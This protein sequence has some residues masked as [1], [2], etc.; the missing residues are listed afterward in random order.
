[1]VENDRSFEAVPTRGGCARGPRWGRWLLR[2]AAAW[3]VVFL[4]AWVAAA[5]VWSHR[6]RLVN[7]W[8][9]G[10]SLPVRA[11]VEGLDWRRGRIVLHQLT[12]RDPAGRVVGTVRTVTAVV[13]AGSLQRRTLEEV[14]IEGV[15]FSAT[16]ESWAAL[17]SASSGPGSTRAGSPSPAAAGSR[18]AGPA[19]KVAKLTV[20][21]A[22]ADLAPRPGARLQAS[23]DWI[24]GGIVSDAAGGVSFAPQHLVVHALEAAAPDGGRISAPGA[25]VTWSWQPEAGPR[26]PGELN[27]AE[28]H[29]PRGALTLTPGLLGL[30]GSGPA[31][32]GPD[33]PAGPVPS[34]A[35]RPRVRVGSLT[36]G[37]MPVAWQFPGQTTVA[38]EL[39]LTAAGLEW[40]PDWALAHFSARLREAAARASGPGETSTAAAASVDLRGHRAAGGPVV[41]EAVTLLQPVVRLNGERWGPQRPAGA[42]A[43]VASSARPPSPFPASGPAPSSFRP[44]AVPAVIVRAAII[45][46]GSLT[47]AGVSGTPSRRE[48][49]AVVTRDIEGTARD[50]TVFADGRIQSAVAQEVALGATEVAYLDEAPVARWHALSLR[51][52]PDALFGEHRIERVH[53]DGPA[54]LIDGRRLR[55]WQRGASA[56]AA[57]AAGPAATAGAPEPPE[58]RSWRDLRIV[59]LAVTGGGAEVIGLGAGWPDGGGGFSIQTAPDGG[60]RVLGHELTMA[61][62]EQ[63]GVPVATLREVEVRAH[64][65]RLA[66]R[67]IDA[68]RI[69]GA[70]VLVGPGL[71]L[72]GPDAPQPSGGRP[73]AA[74][75]SAA[76]EEAPPWLLG[77]LEVAGSRVEV[78]NVLPMLDPVEFEVAF[79]LDQLPLTRAG[80]MNAERT[81]QRVEL[82]NLRLNSA[83]GSPGSLPVAEFSNIFIEFSLAGLLQQ[84]IERV[85]VV[86]PTVYVGEQLFWYVDYFRKYAARQSS[87]LPLAGGAGMPPRA[88]ADTDGAAGQAAAAKEAEAAAAALVLARAGSGGPWSVGQIDAHFGIF[89]IALKGS[90]MDA[91]PALPFSCTTKLD[92]GRVELALDI[93]R[94]TYRPSTRLPLEID[95]TEGRAEFNLPVREQDNNLVQVFKAREIRY[96]Q[97]AAQ[98]VF[99]TLTYDRHGVYARFGG[100]L[101][102]GYLGGGGDLYLD[103]NTSWDFWID[104]NDIDLDPLTRALVPEYFSLSGISRF[105]LRSQGDLESLYVATGDFEATTP[106]RMVIHSI[107]TLLEKLPE[108][109]TLLKRGL[110]QRSLEAFRDYAFDQCR[111]DLRLHGREGKAALRLSGPVGARTFDLEMHDHRHRTRTVP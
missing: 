15:R 80:L 61:A 51:F 66:A 64:P 101:Y 21:D 5:L 18:P 69:S 7:R 86:S 108:E 48:S 53:L 23:F 68:V 65:D 87:R 33:H 59:D 20:R 99:L 58:G 50:L 96:Q 85:E 27:L 56:G 44:P 52:T 41:I 17:L 97:L 40:G 25:R 92:Q 34:A 89:R 95:V 94:G 102:G 79:T 60:Y 55:Q 1:M 90:V 29:W 77:A 76:A 4:L 9:E 67:T 73:G 35:P 43:A 45:S 19:W 26:Q 82:A 54:L 31:A 37:F 110:T 78:G 74:P 81:T 49:P 84:R 100:D 91:L 62:A 39:A 42:A 111:G 46:G 36:L 57:V 38:T 8:L 107:D 22:S 28:L 13:A 103:D 109:W 6:V 24:G 106:G 93:P 47:M 14:A 63:P 10:L 104:G 88:L 83:Y 3:V 98:Q 32:D 71:Q 30:L 72:L 2:M 70:R 75:A 11:G 16:P 105:K 12:L